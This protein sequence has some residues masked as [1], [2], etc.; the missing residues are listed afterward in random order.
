MGPLLNLPRA[1]LLNG[2][3][4]QSLCTLLRNDMRIIAGV[5][6]LVV[7]VVAL[8]QQQVVRPP[9]ANYWVSVDTAAGMTVPGM[10]GMGGLMAGMMGGQAQSGR[11]VVLQLGS[12]RP[13]ADGPRADHL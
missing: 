9:V 13:S 4:Q 3:R 11:S 12:Q 7:P 2:P 6:L 8:A 10:G 1:T 5:I